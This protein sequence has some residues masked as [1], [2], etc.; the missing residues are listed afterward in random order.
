MS[1]YI[2]KQI[3]GLKEEDSVN[4][5]QLLSELLMDSGKTV[6]G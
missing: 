3:Q 4:Q 2:S 6:G 5:F 1:A